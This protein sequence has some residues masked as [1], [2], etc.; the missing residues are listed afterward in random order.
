MRLV[1][2]AARTVDRFLFAPID[3]RVYAG[4]RI[5]YA[6]VCL[7]TVIDLWPLR[8]SLFCRGGMIARSPLLPWYLPLR[9]VDSRAGVTAVMIAVGVCSVF[10]AVGLLTRASTLVLYLWAFSYTAVAYPAE[11]G[12]D[13]LA[14]LAGLALVVSPTAKRWAIDGVLF[15][16]GPAE[17]PRYGL[18][19]LQW[20]L[21]VVYAVTVWL[22]VP[23]PYWRNGELMSYFMMSIFSRVATPSW[24]EW[25]RASALLTWGT[26]L[27]ESAIPFLLF[28]TRGRRLGIACGIALHGGIALASTIGMFSLC[29]TPY[30]AAF[31]EAADFDAL[32]ARWS[33]LLEGANLGWVARRRQ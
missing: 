15:G 23:D 2:E 3:A 16:S 28:S 14:R 22:K 27:L 30:Y 8:H 12:Y 11:S 4:V 7:A 20:Q 9:W 5:A 17:V 6:V 25:G 31:L 29:M 21:A 13:G 24:A 18:R 1:R 33:T 32:G 19:L 10:T 26:L